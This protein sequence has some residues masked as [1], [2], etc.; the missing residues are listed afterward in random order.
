MVSG[1]I[2]SFINTKNLGGKKKMRKQLLIGVLAMLVLTSIAYAVT[3]SFDI[4]AASTQGT[5]ST[6]LGRNSTGGVLIQMNVSLG[7]GLD[8]SSN[9]T[10][11]TLSVSSGTLAGSV[12]SGLVGSNTTKNFNFTVDVGGINDASGAITFTATVYNVSGQSLTTC[13]R[14]YYMDNGKPQCDGAVN[15]AANSS[16]F[17]SGLRFIGSASNITSCK[18]QVGN[19]YTGTVNG[20]AGST[21]NCYYTFPSGEPAEYI[22]N[23]VKMQLSDGLNEST[24]TIMKDITIDDDKNKLGKLAALQ[25][26]QLTT[27]STPETPTPTPTNWLA[28]GII[29]GVIYFI[30][31]KKGKR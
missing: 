11:A 29:I 13:T 8:I 19:W 17:K 15:P 4:P 27:T 2:E 12:R 5:A 24:C 21:Q 14:V 31:K 16:T 30:A 6:Y 26:G 22:Y 28:I 23:T 18:L 7:D 1:V 20:T 9:A 3:C 25:S 10:N